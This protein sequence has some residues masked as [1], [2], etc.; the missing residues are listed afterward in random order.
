MESTWNSLIDVLAELKIP[1]G[2]DP[3]SQP[4]S[5]VCQLA[6]QPSTSY[7]VINSTPCVAITFTYGYFVFFCI[8]FFHQTIGFFGRL[9]S[10]GVLRALPIKH[11]GT[12]TCFTCALAIQIV[13]FSLSMQNSF[14]PPS[15]CVYSIF[16]STF[17]FFIFVS[18]Q[19]FSFCSK[20][21][22]YFTSK[23]KYKLIV[24]LLLL[25]SLVCFP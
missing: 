5:P 6:S 7:T 8:C 1:T 13:R 17:R 15:M 20:L 19:F 12:Y 22:K 9:H 16:M 3:A 25:F 18:F 14:L 10:L 2:N 11:S 23:F 21:L 24:L 4:A